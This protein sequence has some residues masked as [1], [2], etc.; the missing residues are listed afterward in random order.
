MWSFIFSLPL[1]TRY[2]FGLLGVMALL[3]GSF[4]FWKKGKEEHYDEHELIDLT[5]ITLLWSLLGARLVYV[6]M[7]FSDFGL[8]ILYWFSIWSKP[9][10][11]WVGLFG[12]GTLAF[13]RYCH[14][15]KWNYF[16]VFDLAVIGIALSQGLLN[17]G[18]FLSAS[19]LGKTT[20][21]PLGVVF[22]GSFEKRHPIGLYAFFL[23][24]GVFF[25][26][27]W[28]EGKYR[29]F[30][31]YQKF[32]GDALPGFLSFVYIIAFGLIGSLTAIFSEVSTIYYGI[33]LD[34]VIRL[35]LVILGVTGIFV[36][37]GLVAKLGLD[38][39]SLKLKK[40]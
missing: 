40:K 20:S 39:L 26:L 28:L 35:I 15:H 5:L 19:G 10:F 1:I 27:W 32:K 29:R 33:N 38:K 13:I 14:A 12:G 30:V 21:M 23:W 8:N 24:M 22:P 37:S 34:L 6:L 7:H 17:L 18:I 9:G 3:F 31:W 11:H 36:R 4:A 16:K 25:F 2:S